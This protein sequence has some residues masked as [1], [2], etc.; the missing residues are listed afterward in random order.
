[1][2]VSLLAA[3]NPGCCSPGSCDLLGTSKIGPFVCT[4]RSITCNLIRNL[5]L[6]LHRT[7]STSSSFSCQWGKFIR[8]SFFTISF[9][10]AECPYGHCRIWAPSH[11][12]QQKAALGVRMFCRRSCPSGRILNCSAICFTGIML[13]NAKDPLKAFLW[14]PILLLL[15]SVQIT[16][17]S[18]CW[19]WVL[20]PPEH[21]ERK[22]LGS[23][24]QPWLCPCWI[25]IMDV[26][27]P[28]TCVHPQLVF[29]QSNLPLFAFPETPSCPKVQYFTRKPFS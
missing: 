3:W 17:P 26:H 23:S 21:A 7:L 25:H 9:V 11:C 1:M 15:L 22:A 27:Y 19:F 5:R 8:R 29:P 4:N 24:S 12:C 13:V 18:C 14:C 16:S 2:L 28:F 6:E 20:S 10:S